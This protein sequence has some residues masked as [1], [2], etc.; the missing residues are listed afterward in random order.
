MSFLASIL[1]QVGKF[2][3]SVV[4]DIAS[5]KPIGRSLKK[6]GLETVRNLPVIG[7]IA[8]PL[9]ELGITQAQKAIKK[10]APKKRKQQINKLF[11]ARLTPQGVK[12]AGVATKLLTGKDIVKEI[13]DAP[14]G[15]VDDILKAGLRAAKNKK[16]KL[17][18]SDVDDIIDMAIDLR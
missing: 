8:E 15:E 7:E 14:V 12:R 18:R 1:P 5:G 17:S 16:G 4:K 3:A 9:L 10:K 2:G 13:R 11:G 6:R